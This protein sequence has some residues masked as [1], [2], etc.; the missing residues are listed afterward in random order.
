MVGVDVGGTHNPPAVGATV[1]TAT[2][3]WS[4]AP[5]VNGAVERARRPPS[6]FVGRTFNLTDSTLEE[7]HAERRHS[8]NCFRPFD[9]LGEPLP[10]TAWYNLLLL[11]SSNTGE[12]AIAQETVGDFNLMF[13]D[14]TTDFQDLV[15]H[16]GPQDARRVQK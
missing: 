5:Q 15:V 16:A 7:R 2:P 8:S 9:N 3:F 10:S 4:L 11:V 14:Q 6:K 1:R 12:A 13:G